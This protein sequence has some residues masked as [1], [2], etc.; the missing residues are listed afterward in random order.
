MTEKS[1]NLRNDLRKDVLRAVSNIRKE[2]AKLRC[3]VE[4]KNKLIVDLE[5]KAAETNSTLKALQCGVGCNCREDKWATSAGEQVTSK[6]SD[7]NGAP[8]AGQ[9]RKRYSDGP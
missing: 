9:T 4:D 6:D 5:K 3:E 8:S 7:W 1:A 2:F